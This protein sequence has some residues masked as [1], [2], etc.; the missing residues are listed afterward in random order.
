VAAAVVLAAGTIAILAVAPDD[1][2][3]Q[4]G[5][6]ALVMAYGI[7]V[8][9]GL[10]SG[11]TRALVIE[12]LFALAG[13]AIAVLGLRQSSAWLA[14][15]LFLHGLWDFLHHADRRSVG[16]ENVPAWYI[17]ACVVYDWLVAAAVLVLI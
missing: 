7:Y 15:G 17:P 5:A 6:L 1:L 10:T 9:M 8:G 4:V 13:L 2:A 3:V 12:A 16:V 11:D 14:G